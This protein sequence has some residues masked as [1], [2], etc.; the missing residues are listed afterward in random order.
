MAVVLAQN[1]LVDL[2]TVLGELGL[3]ADPSG[4]P[5]TRLINVASARIESYVQRSLTFAQRVETYATPGG[6]RPA[7]LQLNNCP[8]YPPA[9]AS[10]VSVEL[11]LD[12]G[13]FE[14]VQTLLVPGQDFFLEDCPR[15]WL[16]RLARWP[17]TALRR[18]DLVQD[19][20]PDNVE[21]TTQVTYLGG[22]VTPVQVE[23]ALTAWPTGTTP[24]AAAL[25]I[26]AGHTSQVWACT[27]PGAVGGS[28]PTW[29]TSP[30][31]FETIVDGAATWT[32]L[33][34]NPTGAY[35]QAR[36]LPYEIEQAAVDTVVSTYRRRGQTL[37]PTAE[38]FGDAS[39][40]YGERLDLPT[41]AQRLLAP[42]KRIVIG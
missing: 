24:A 15:G 3:G 23:A 17:S 33:G 26:P 6:P 27:V 14:N 31:K 42:F 12:P 10:I 37:E 18:P 4:N 21:L 8:V 9:L 38:R 30:S 5:I 34:Y 36:T 39:Q 16:F 1:A 7:R 35:P 13:V 32:F 22:F 41:S 2:A 11:D 40:T 20:D 19:W 28:E 29:G 25:L